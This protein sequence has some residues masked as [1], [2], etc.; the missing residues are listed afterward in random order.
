MKKIFI[1]LI[2]SILTTINSNGQNSNERI[3][4]V[5]DSIPI[6]NEPEE[7]L[8]SLSPDDIDNLTV[9]KGEK[10]IDSLGYKDLD[11]IIYIFTKE[12]AKRSDSIKKIP[13]TNNM[14]RKNYEWYLKKSSNTYSGKFIDYYINGKKQGEGFFNNGKVN[15]L[16]KM[17]YPNG[18]I[19]MERVYLNGNENGIE[20]EFYQDG[21]LKQTGEFSNGKEIGIWEMYH[22]NGQLKQ[23]SS[24]ENG[25]MTGESISYYSTGKFRSTEKFENGI[26]IKDKENSKK[27]DLYSDG[28]NYDKIGNFK[29]SIK[30]YSKAIEIDS[31]FADGY[32]ARGTAKLNNLE[33]DEAIIDFNKTLEIEPFFAKA[34]GNRAFALIRKFE[35]ANSRTLSNNSEI[36][37][38]ATKDNVEIPENELEKICSDISKSESL[39]IK[40]KMIS[41]AKE[42][43]CK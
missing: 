38:L 40:N 43:F 25:K 10:A 41:D 30:K 34:Y 17:Y 27:Y 16:R 23:K 20:K 11:G 3:L 6:I 18:Q 35:F 39:G 19:S 24:F 37:I 33:F 5:I 15:G 28:I 1:L 26:S 7:G 13:S 32:F 14:D 36:T 2:I 9:Y 22:S 4:Y 42:K 21:T 31:T 8:N 12:Y 29:K